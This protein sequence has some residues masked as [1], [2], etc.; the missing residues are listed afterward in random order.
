MGFFHY[1]PQKILHF[2][3][4]IGARFGRFIFEWVS[5]IVDP[6]ARA[7]IALKDK[8]NLFRLFKEH[9]SVWCCDRR[10]YYL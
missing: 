2:G 6:L 7:F 9:Y 3:S 8:R 10:I 4:K 1:G 5:V